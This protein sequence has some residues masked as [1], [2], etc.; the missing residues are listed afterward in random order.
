MSANIITVCCWLSYV[1]IYS[2]CY[3]SIFRLCY[4]FIFSLCYV[5]IF[6]LCSVRFLVRVMCVFSL[7]YVLRLDASNPRSARVGSLRSLLA[8]LGGASH[9]LTLNVYQE[10]T[11]SAL[12]ILV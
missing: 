10:L 6:S 12:R 1:L 2:M 11:S 8:C 4:V 7:C 3:V 9:Y 5:S